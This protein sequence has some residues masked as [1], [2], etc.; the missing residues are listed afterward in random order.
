MAPAVGGKRWE[1][2]ASRWAGCP[3]SSHSA[4]SSPP[5]LAPQQAE[6]ATV[7]WDLELA[8]PAR[9]AGFR[10]IFLRAVLR[11]LSFACCR[12]RAHTYRRLAAPCQ[13]CARG[14]WLGWG[15]CGRFASSCGEAARGWLGAL[16]GPTSFLFSNSISGPALSSSGRPAPP[17][18]SSGQ[19]HSRS[20]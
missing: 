12:P 16:P 1:L 2:G 10:S 18:P 6:G 8:L 19:G 3:P 4:S 14:S 20:G 13:F 17:P 15:A 11:H 5:Q 7:L 9:A